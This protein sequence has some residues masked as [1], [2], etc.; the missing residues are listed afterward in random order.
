[1]KVSLRVAVLQLQNPAL[2]TSLVLKKGLE[3]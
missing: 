2:G 1:V 3:A